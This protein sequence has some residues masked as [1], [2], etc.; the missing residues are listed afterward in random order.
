MCPGMIETNIRNA[1]H[2]RRTSKSALTVVLVLI[3]AAAAAGLIAAA[4]L[5]GGGSAGSGRETK[6]LTISGRPSFA[7]ARLTAESAA[8]KILP[9]IVGVIQY[10]GSSANETG[11]GSGVIMSSDGLIIT[12][13]HVISGAGRLEAV[14][15]V[16]KRYPASVTGFDTRTDLA[17][18]K[19]NAKGLCR[20]EFGDSSGCRVG[21]A[22]IAAGNPSG[23]MLA[24]SVTQGIISAL[25]R[26]VD[27][28][29]G[30]M[31]LIQTDAA[32]NPGNS[33]GPLI[34]ERG[35]VLGINTMIV[36]NT[37]GIGFAIP[38][39]TVFEEFSLVPT[40]EG[41]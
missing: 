24:G 38:V 37:E 26:Y 32:I 10:R 33:G 14:T 5:F 28:G 19:I 36:Q 23:M 35:R 22:V 7:G 20:A 39:T 16:G 13:Y 1:S 12:N 4:A 15:R 29:S 40:P 34:D 11:E 25:D 18:I 6:A 41:D 21:E 31:K 27:I 30:P 8:R 3:S 17:V 2:G 9:S